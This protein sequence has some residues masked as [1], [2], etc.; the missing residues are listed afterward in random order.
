VSD[1]EKD[2]KKHPLRGKANMKKKKKVE[3]HWIID[4]QFFGSFYLSCDI[5]NILPQ[6]LQI[7]LLRKK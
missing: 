5:L 1:Y 2:L 6:I 3:K 7:L 4:I